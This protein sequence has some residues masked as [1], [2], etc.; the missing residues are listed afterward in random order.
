METQQPVIAEEDHLLTHLDNCYKLFD[1]DRTV[2][3]NEMTK[4]IQSPIPP[5]VIIAAFIAN[6]RNFVELNVNDKFIQDY[7]KKYNIEDAT[8]LEELNE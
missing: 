6:T 4:F 8:Q 2:P 3:I 1:P 7:I 5:V